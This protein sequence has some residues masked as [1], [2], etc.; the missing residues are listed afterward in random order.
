MPKE[1]LDGSP[2]EV[3]KHYTKDPTRVITVNEC[4][5][6]AIGNSETNETGVM[7]C[8]NGKDSTGADHELGIILSEELIGMGLLE[9]VRE[10]FDE[11]MD[12]KVNLQ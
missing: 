3:L 12:Q 5:P 1:E 10:V 4:K 7:L 9:G 2:E 8:I 6:I 11:G